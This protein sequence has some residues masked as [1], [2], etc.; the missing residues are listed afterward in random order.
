[1]ENKPLMPLATAV[2]LVDNTSLSFAQISQFC[3]LHELEIQSIADGEEAYNMKGLNPI[4]SGQLT[5]D[6]IK[7]CED[8]SNAELT[9]QT[10]K[11]QKIHIR[12]NTKK[13][14]PLSVRS[15]RPKAIAWLVRE[16]GKI[17][18]DIQIAKLTSSTKPTVANIRAGNQA[19]PI[20]EFR[21]PTDLGLCTY[22]E[23]E[24]IIEKGQRKAERDLK[25]KEKAKNT[26]PSL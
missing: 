12:S 19:Q 18:T 2:W 8:D 9:L 25:A 11:S 17:L 4:A 22:E 26:I 15:E 14:L 7:R 21:S 10:H 23:L 13:Y 1:M 5:K 20:T 24:K 3:Q 16:Y 6:E